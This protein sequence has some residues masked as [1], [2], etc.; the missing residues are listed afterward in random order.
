MFKTLSFALL[1]PVLA[2]SSGESGEK[3]DDG[4]AGLPDLPGGDD[5]SADA[6]D[7]GTASDDD[8]DAGPGDDPGDDPSD[9]SGDVVDDEI[10][11]PPGLNGT[12]VEPRLPAPEFMATNYDGSTRMR[13]D[14]EYRPTVMWFYPVAGTPG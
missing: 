10:V 8:A 6:G 12:V 5:G 7:S 4:G 1:L 9:D 3:S 11:L 14:L 13:S 2:C